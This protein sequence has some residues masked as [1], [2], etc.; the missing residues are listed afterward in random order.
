MYYKPMGGVLEKVDATETPFL[1]KHGNGRIC[2]GIDEAIHSMKVG[3]K[4]RAIIPP[5]IGLSDGTMLQRIL[6]D[7]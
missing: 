7:R 5:N 4:R 3:G 1:H 2:R 6:S